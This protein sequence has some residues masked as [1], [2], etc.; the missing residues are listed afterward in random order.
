MVSEQ[1]TAARD[2]GR[3][4][5]IFA[6][7]A[8]NGSVVRVHPE[9]CVPYSNI[10]GVSKHG[11]DRLEA[12][13]SQHGYY[14]LS[15]KP[16]ICELWEDDQLLHARDYI[17]IRDCLSEDA[18]TEA[19]QRF[20]KWYGIVDGGHRIAALIR[21]TR[22]RGT[23]DNFM[24]NAS[25]APPHTPRQDLVR[26]ARANNDLSDESHRVEATI[27]EQI[28]GMQYEAEEMKREKQLSKNPAPIEVARAYCGNP[29]LQSKSSF[30]QRA[31]IAMH[32]STEAVDVIG[33]ITSYE[34]NKVKDT[35]ADPRTL[36]KLVTF[37]LLKNAGT[38]LF[39]AT[40]AVQAACLH[41]VMYNAIA[42]RKVQ[43]AKSELLSCLKGATFALKEI[44]KVDEMLGQQTWPLG[45]VALKDNLLKTTQ[46]DEDCESWTGNGRSILTV[47][48][49]RFLE[50]GGV[51][52]EAKLLYFETGKL[53][54]PDKD[55]A[56]DAE[57][58]EHPVSP[59]AVGPDS[60]EGQSTKNKDGNDGNLTP[61]E[62][63]QEEAPSSANNDGPD[64]S[65]PRL[66]KPVPGPD[67]VLAS[68]GMS[69]FQGRWQDVRSSQ[70]M[71][72][73]LAGS[74]D[75]VLTDIPS[76]PSCA[77]P[78]NRQPWDFIEDEEIDKF[79]QMSRRMLKPGSYL[80][81][82]HSTKQFH[83]LSLALESSKFSYSKSPVII[84]QEQSSIQKTTA[85]YLPQ[86][87]YN[88]YTV[89]Y[90][91]IDSSTR[92]FYPR[93]DDTS[94][95]YKV[96]K[97]S[98]KR[99]FDVI[100][101]V[102]ARAPKLCRPGRKTYVRRCEKPVD[103]LR[104]IIDMYCPT[105]GREWCWIPTQGPYQLG[106]RVLKQDDGAFSSKLTLGAFCL[107]RKGS[108]SMPRAK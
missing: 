32:M 53:P 66:E 10:R 40:P 73:E 89:A 79:V 46:L 100:V 22:S 85:V 59:P 101:D 13:F 41:R 58:V 8:T 31:R 104:E 91:E 61:Q 1:E 36:R 69:V 90:S 54:S 28:L 49:R 51:G 29:D 65:R 86:H 5:E 20:E 24:F 83:K 17:K 39:S 95:P 103:L 102:P 82:F 2:Q 108:S 27:H 16:L 19:M 55:P 75:L 3:Q 106:L 43:C 56:P 64:E 4:R 70:D 97:T 92:V 18:A 68:L 9:Q 99:K 11:V 47:L 33:E 93:L 84:A 57:D 78:G 72:D 45:M 105:D 30:V 63:D 15:G 35:D 23:W 76:E 81:I 6:D 37:N 67:E 77:K 88:Q 34:S 71:F 42:E 12:I 14:H 25:L 7:W 21:L 87:S 26:A 52:A 96:L 50:V 60:H 74:V 80:V 94:H 107:L 48:R 38:L 44:E 98:S 62:P